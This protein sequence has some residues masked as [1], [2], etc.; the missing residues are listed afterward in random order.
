MLHVPWPVVP[1]VNICLTLLE[2]LTLANNFYKYIMLNHACIHIKK[3]NE[4]Y[5]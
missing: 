5:H 3:V 4:S 2:F 1:S